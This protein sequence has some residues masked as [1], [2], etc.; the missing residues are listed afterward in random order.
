M[1]LLNKS[2]LLAGI[3]LTALIVAG[4]PVA[5]YAHNGEDD[6]AS[7]SSHSGPTTVGLRSS[8]DQVVPVSTDDS[9][10]DSVR[11]RAE[12][13]L[14]EKRQNRRE[15]TQTERQKV[16]QN[17]EGVINARF[18]KLGTKAG[19][20]LNGFNNIFEKVQAYQEKKQ[21]DV[22]N[23]D[24]LVADVTAAQATAADTVAALD[25]LA[26]SKIDCTAEDPA[27]TVASVRTAVQ[28]ARDAL[29]SYRSALKKL[30][31]ALHDAKQAAYTDNASNGS[32]D[33]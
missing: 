33:N 11:D 8:D 22:A 20:Y 27:T 17:R 23:Y 30:V 15:H 1:K 6:S 18:E 31:H 25:A 9:G 19:R 26:G 21:L 5:V 7:T 2:K 13:L 4:S 12:K 14:Q 29:Q 32:E 16:C 24:E 10:E 3:V 28:D